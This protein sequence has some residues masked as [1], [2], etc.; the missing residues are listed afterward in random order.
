MVFFTG[1][2][3][4]VPCVICDMHWLRSIDPLTDC[5]GGVP[6]SNKGNM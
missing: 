3:D 2:A 6:S 5:Y 1:R 4:L